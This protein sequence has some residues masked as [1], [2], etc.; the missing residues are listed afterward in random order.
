MTK[1]L[2]HVW[3]TENSPPYR[4]IDLGHHK[5]ETKEIAQK[6]AEEKFKNLVKNMIRVNWTWHARQ[7]IVEVSRARKVKPI[8]AD[9]FS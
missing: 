2:W 3:A 5:G 6:K 8:S 1:E 7:E 4:E 9:M